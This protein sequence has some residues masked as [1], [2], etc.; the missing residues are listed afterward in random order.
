MAYFH[1]D[2]V[3]CVPG[4][5]FPCQA[6]MNFGRSPAAEQDLHNDRGVKDDQCRSLSSR[7]TDTMDARVA[8]GRNFDSLARI[9]LGA[10]RKLVRS[11]SASK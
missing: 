5:F 3:R 11:S 1:F 4:L 7:N 8:T 2:Q 6:R 9:S 10:G